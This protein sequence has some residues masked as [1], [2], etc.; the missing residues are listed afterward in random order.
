MVNRKSPRCPQCS[1][2]FMWQNLLDLHVQYF[3]SQGRIQQSTCL[4]ESR[5]GSGHSLETIVTSKK[6]RKGTEKIYRH[7]NEG[8]WDDEIVPYN[9][10]GKRS[11]KSNKFKLTLYKIH[12][13]H[14]AKSIRKIARALRQGLASVH[15]PYGMKPKDMHQRKS[16][17]CQ[18]RSHTMN[19]FKE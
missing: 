1:Q 17:R 10:D 11:C 3:H 16:S 4:D 2:V 6:A 13:H 8:K 5:R 7:V 14:G 9:D 19:S 12:C 18:T 15:S